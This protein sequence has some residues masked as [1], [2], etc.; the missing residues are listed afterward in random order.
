MCDFPFR[1][2]QRTRRRRR[3]CV[4]SGTRNEANPSHVQAGTCARLS[5]NNAAA[6]ILGPLHEAERVGAPVGVPVMGSLCTAYPVG[7]L[8]QLVAFGI[9]AVLRCCDWALAENV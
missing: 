9:P 7:T 6:K 3:K 4:R 8:S 5:H 1:S 2:L